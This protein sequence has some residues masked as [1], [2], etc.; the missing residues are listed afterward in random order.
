[1]FLSIFQRFASLG[2]DSTCCWVGSVIIFTP[3]GDN[4]LRGVNGMSVDDGLKT[5]KYL[6][7]NQ[8]NCYGKYKGN[9]RV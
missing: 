5:N 9:E 7:F 2:T 3:N 1:M 8:S 6:E 4:F